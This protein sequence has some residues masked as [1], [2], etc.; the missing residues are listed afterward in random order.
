VEAGD[1]MKN[2]TMLNRVV[3]CLII[4]SFVAMGNAY[5]N[6][7][8]LRV[9][10]GIWKKKGPENNKEF[11]P[12]RI[13]EEMPKELIAEGDLM[14]SILRGAT[15]F[16]LT[17]YYELP[18]DKALKKAKALVR[19]TV[20]DERELGAGKNMVSVSFG[21]TQIRTCYTNG[22]D[23]RA[24]QEST[25][26]KSATGKISNQ[27]SEEDFV[28][29][30]FNRISRVI[31]NAGA[32]NVQGV[33]I[34]LPGQPDVTG[35]IACDD[36]QNPQVP[37]IYKFALGS[38][39]EEKLQKR[40][41]KSI[42][43][44][45]K[46]DCTLGTEYELSERGTFKGKYKSGGTFLVGS[47]LNIQG[48]K[49]NSVFTGED[50][51]EGIMVE[52]G[53]KITANLGDFDPETS[54]FTSRLEEWKGDKFPPKSDIDA[55][56]LRFE[57]AIQGGALNKF[58][59]KYGFFVPTEGDNNKAKLPDLTEAARNGNEKA[60]KVIELYSIIAAKGYAAFI[61]TGNNIDSECF[62][63]VA[64]ISTVFQKLGRD[65]EFE[66][67]HNAARNSASLSE[68][69]LNVKKSFELSFGYSPS[70]IARGPG[71]PNIIGEHVDYPEFKIYRNPGNATDIRIPH[72]YSLPFAA[73]QNVL[74]AA[75]PRSDNKIVAYFVNYGSKIEIDLDKIDLDKLD[76]TKDGKNRFQDAQSPANY[77]LG[78]YKAA[79]EKGLKYGGAEF[80][81]E[82]NIP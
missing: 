30:L 66:S 11:T 33:Q 14:L 71:R 79:K 20:G 16:E 6:Q 15:Y 4:A 57:A 42:A 75:K 61:A 28:K 78:V 51:Y 37:A 32:K 73:Q 17:E 1:G 3:S 76:L 80:V 46:N 26:W 43:V 50:A 18:K 72:N 21:G 60:R 35:K 54:H 24:Y 34:G 70:V 8:T 19:S 53:H 9:P 45:L 29:V 58:A 47:G 2:I 36:G 41:G 69:E 7:D 22:Q 39:L 25:S 82:G 81:I 59:K 55:K 67:S 64:L 44:T 48:V 10:I 56:Y 12:Q 65:V 74:V 52:P 68:R 13:R 31:D 38:A 40:Y 49:G 23:E 5:P 77:L 62:D 63:H 27:L